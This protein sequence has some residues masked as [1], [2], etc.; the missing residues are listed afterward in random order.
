[1]TDE[2]KIGVIDVINDVLQTNVSYE[3]NRKR[4]EL[5]SW[6]SLKHMELILLLEEA[7]NIRM[8]LEQVSAIESTDDLIHIVGQCLRKAD[9]R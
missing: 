7:F 6:D 3:E 5:P 2:L 8:S 1:M 9:D 4:I